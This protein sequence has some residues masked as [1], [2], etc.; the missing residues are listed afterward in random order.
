MHA[1]IFISLWL[2]DWLI[3]ILCFQAAIFFWFFWLTLQLAKK[4]SHS[5]KHTAEWS[6][7]RDVFCSSWMGTS[8]FGGFGPTCFSV[9]PRTRG[10][11]DTARL[12]EVAHPKRSM[13]S[14]N[15]SS[16]CS[17]TLALLSKQESETLLWEYSFLKEWGFPSDQELEESC[18]PNPGDWVL[19]LSIPA[20]S[21]S[22]DKPH[23][24]WESTL[25][26]KQP[27]KS[28]DLAD[29]PLLLPVAEIRVLHSTPSRRLISR[30]K[31]LQ[32]CGTLS[33]DTSVV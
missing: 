25:G 28:E 3:D 6:S 4:K 5:A 2:I 13:P 11:A 33:V 27:E 17:V 26:F 31:A 23:R 18:Y 21:T 24:P 15:Q 29:I 1:H 20:P 14:H 16:D 10:L 19:T 9:C 22:Q 30:C 7:R 32:A 12:Y 8:A